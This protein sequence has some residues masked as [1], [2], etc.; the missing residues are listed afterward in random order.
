MWHQ[1]DVAIPGELVA[2]R[3]AGRYAADADIGQ[4]QRLNRDAGMVRLV[5]ER[6]MHRSD[7]RGAER[8]NPVAVTRRAF[9]KQHHGVAVAQAVAHL[10]GD[11]T[12]LL[13]SLALDE[14]RALQ[15]GEPSEQRPA[16]DLVLGDKHH[17]CDRGDDDDVEPRDVVGQDQQRLIARTLPDFP[18]TNPDDGADGAVIQVRDDTL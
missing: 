15:L 11:F 4:R 3:P 14:Y 18:D 6:V 12:G 8:Q 5:A 9:R 17:W 13:A 2:Q 10:A 16:R 1:I 7:Q